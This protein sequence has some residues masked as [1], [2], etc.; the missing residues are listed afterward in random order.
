MQQ[1]QLDIEAMKT[2]AMD[3]SKNGELAAAE[4]AQQQQPPIQ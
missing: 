1:Q 4:A 2:P 3:P